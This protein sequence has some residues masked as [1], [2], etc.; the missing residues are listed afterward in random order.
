MNED[1]Y[2]FDLTEKLAKEIESGAELHISFQ[3]SDRINQFTAR[4]VQVA[5]VH[6]RIV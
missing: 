5:Q 2:E 3:Q 6:R 4:V 1:S